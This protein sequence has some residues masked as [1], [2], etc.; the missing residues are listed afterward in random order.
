MICSTLSP[1][2][3][4]LW[5]PLLRSRVARQRW[6]AHSSLIS[7][8]GS[9]RP[10]AAQ[11]QRRVCSHLCRLSSITALFTTGSFLQCFKPTTDT[12]TIIHKYRAPLV[13]C[14]PTSHPTRL[15]D[16][17]TVTS[18][19]VLHDAATESRCVCHCLPPQPYHFLPALLLP[20]C[21]SSPRLLGRKDLRLFTLNFSLSRT[22]PNRTRRHTLSISTHTA[23]P[24]Q[25]TLSTRANAWPGAAAGKSLIV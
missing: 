20:A 21:P 3:A 9:A 13:F 1:T 18:L 10:T 5:P 24:L 22:H 7:T 14:V 6:A 23:S 2:L 4:T 17:G 19:P 12:S 15:G 16:T 25:A 8:A 11:Q